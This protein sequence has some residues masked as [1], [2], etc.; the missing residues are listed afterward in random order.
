MTTL[1]SLIAS[2]SLKE[3][4]KH[5]TLPNIALYK[6]RSGRLFSQYSLNCEMAK[7]R[8]IASLT[9]MSPLICHEATCDPSSIPSGCYAFPLAFSDLKNLPQKGP[10]TPSKCAKLFCTMI[11]GFSLLHGAQIMHG[12]PK[13]E[14]ILIFDD[15]CSIA[16]LEHA[17]ILSSKEEI[18][19]YVADVLYQPPEGCAH[20]PGDIYI[21]GLNTI[22]LLTATLSSK[23]V[24]LQTRL[25][26]AGV[27]DTKRYF[28]PLLIFNF[29]A[30]FLRWAA[31]AGFGKI[32]LDN[33]AKREVIT[34]SMIGQ[35]RTEITCL[36]D[37]ID[38]QTRT[39]LT[40]M[41]TCAEKML[42]TDPKKRPTIGQIME[43]LTPP[44]E[45]LPTSITL[46]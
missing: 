46:D 20:L 4:H 11:L 38:E 31:Y 7:N 40:N 18:S 28:G 39:N 23:I 26:L 5:L 12:D 1:G 34:N 9:G 41:L 32:I 35:L 30:S 2:S 16:D 10:I 15:T 36:P 33:T 14:N 19:R 21:L 13:A 27:S 25:V 44:A 6:A 42:A 3:V 8:K 22:N 24:P 45:Q 37:D 29:I 43:I 17:K